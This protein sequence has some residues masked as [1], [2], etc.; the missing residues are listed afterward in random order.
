MEGKDRGRE[1]GRREGQRKNERR[2]REREGME[3]G[4]EGRRK[5]TKTNKTSFEYVLHC[6]SQVEVLFN[7]K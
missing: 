7:F 4:T 2:E 5:V 1:G 6:K 3:K